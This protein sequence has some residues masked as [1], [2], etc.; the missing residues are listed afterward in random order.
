MAALE[1]EVGRHRETVAAGALPLDRRK[2]IAG[3]AGMAHP[4]AKA[5]RVGK[6]ADGPGIGRTAFIIAMVKQ[7][8][9]ARRLGIDEAIPVAGDRFPSRA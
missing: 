9:V 8:G 5:R 6:I 3:L 1:H 7:D 4:A 2:G